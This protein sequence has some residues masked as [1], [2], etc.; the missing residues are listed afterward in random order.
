MKPPV[1]SVLCSLLWVMLTLSGCSNTPEPPFAP[2]VEEGAAL[3]GKYCALCHGPEGEGYA[4]DSA[5]NLNNVTFLATSSDLFLYNAISEGHPGTTM[6]PWADYRG[7]PLGETDIWNIV[8]LLRSWQTLASV[9]VTNAVIKGVALRGEPVY[10]VYCESCH[11]PNGSDGP[12]VTLNNPQFLANASNG[13]IRFAII[14]GRP[15]TPMPAYQSQLSPQDIDDVVTLIRSWEKPI[16]TGPLLLPSLDLGDPTLNPEADDPEFTVGERFISLDSLVEALQTPA[17][18]IL[19]DARP[20]PDYVLGHIPGAVSVP[21][22]AVD[23][24]VDQLPKDTWIVAYCGCPHAESS[25]A[26]DALEAKGFTQ[27]AVLDEGYDAWEET[28]LGVVVGPTP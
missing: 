7:G 10:E 21:F 3:Y 13:F 25:A 27:I 8:G 22:Y 19:L 6:S 2:N 12:Y 23:D 1:H 15:D 24:F 14:N 28:G 4:A 17:K 16:D 11:G 18:L 26:A 20:P 5:T 9:D